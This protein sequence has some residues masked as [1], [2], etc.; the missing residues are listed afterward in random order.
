MKSNT[1]IKNYINA[2]ERHERKI[3]RYWA[4]DLYS[5]LTGRMKVEDFLKDETKNLLS[6]GNIIRG[7]E[8]ESTLKK[9]YDFNKLDYQYQVKKIKKHKDF[10]I[11]VV[12]D[13]L[14]KDMVLEIKS[15]RKEVEEIKPW[16]MPQLEVQYRVFK[17]PICIGY[18]TDWPWVKYYNYIPSDKFWQL[19][20]DKVEEFHNKCLK[21]YPTKDEKNRS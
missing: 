10:E 12:C 13:F 8:K 17:R 7:E 6:C 11:V 3:G 5:I 2:R 4:S 9:I 18:I 19:I 20:L 1:L 15:P 14:F 21:Y 16:H